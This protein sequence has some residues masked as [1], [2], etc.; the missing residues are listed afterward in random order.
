MTLPN[1]KSLGYCH[2]QPAGAANN[3]ICFDNGFHMLGSWG[4]PELSRI[5]T[6][7]VDRQNLSIRMGMRRM[8]RL[9]NAFS[10]KW[11]NL[12]A[13]YALWFAFYNFCRVH[14][15]L[16]VT[17]AMEAGLTDHVWTIDTLLA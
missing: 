1:R 13:A 7:H 14:Q 10:K 8:T 17:P 16:R 2:G 5:C 6:S 11:D 4:Q 9:T 12:K 15:T 3:V